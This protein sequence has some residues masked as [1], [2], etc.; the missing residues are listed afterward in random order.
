MKIGF[1]GAGNM[2]GALATAVT[3]SL[4]G[5]NVYVCDALSEKAKAFSKKHGTH[6]V[7]T[8][9]ICDLCDYIFIG[10]KPQMMR[11]LFDEIK[12]E[13]INRKSTFV[14]VS[15]AAGVSIE[16]IE[17]MCGSSCPIIRIMPNIPVSAQSGMI[18]CTSNSGVSKDQIACFE[19]MMVHAGKLDFIQEKLIDAGSAVS[20]CGP[21]FVSMFIEALAD[22]AV[23]CGIPRDKALDYAVQ[24][25]LGTAKYLSEGS[26]HPACLKDAVCSPAGSTIE[27]VIALENGAFRASVIDAVRAAFERTKELGKQ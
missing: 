23:S 17:Q 6:C 1:I 25:V 16:L 21:A 14:I 12:G 26:G 4:G 22:G 24:T 11:E 19:N 27:G 5:E 8:K 7:T 18:L 9:E 15:M 13:L 3:K 2:G 10:V 20:G